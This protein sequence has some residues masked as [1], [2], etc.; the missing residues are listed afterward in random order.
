MGHRNW[1]KKV[2]HTVCLIVSALKEGEV[3]ENREFGEEG[4]AA[5]LRLP[6]KVLWAE[7]YPLKPPIS[8]P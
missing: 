3:G 2:K 5:I 4:R 6:G 7:L 1:I 8:K